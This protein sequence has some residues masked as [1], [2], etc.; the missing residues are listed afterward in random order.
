M[1]PFDVEPGPQPGKVVGSWDS[2]GNIT[3]VGNLSVGGSASIAGSLTVNGQ[4]I[5]G[6]G[7]GGSSV[8]EYAAKLGLQYAPFD[9]NL[10]ASANGLSSGT[11]VWQLMQPG[12]VT[13]TNL[14]CMVHVKGVTNTGYSGLAIY[15]EAGVLLDKTSDMST[16][17]AAGNDAYIEAAL[18]AGPFTFTA[19][20]DYYLAALTQFSGTSPSIFGVLAQS[21][22]ATVRTH[23]PA[24]FT[25]GQTTFPASFNPAAVS[26]NSGGYWLVGS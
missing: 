12:A 5:T 1:V 6:G 4:N 22:I 11:V 19:G 10:A 23:R 9:I 13:F 20:T 16:A 14:G 8:P 21:N 18:S 24:L 15:T 26:V 7:G 3:T 2:S 25:T 17:F